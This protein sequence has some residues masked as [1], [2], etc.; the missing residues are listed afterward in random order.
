[1]MLKSTE[2]GTSATEVDQRGSEHIKA[3]DIDRF[4]LNQLG[5]LD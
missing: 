4:L 3:L 1:M 2:V 5:A